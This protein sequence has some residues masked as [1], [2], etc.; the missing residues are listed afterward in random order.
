M[1]GL[2]KRLTDSAFDQ[3]ANRQ[4]SYLFGVMVKTSDVV[5]K[6]RS[7]WAYNSLWGRSP[8]SGAMERDGQIAGYSVVAPDH[9][10]LESRKTRTYVDI[11]APDLYSNAG[12]KTVAAEDVTYVHMVTN[13]KSMP[14]GVSCYYY[15]NATA[16]QSNTQTTKEVQEDNVAAGTKPADVGPDN[17]NSDVSSSGRNVPTQASSK[18]VMGTNAATGTHM[19]PNTFMQ[20]LTANFGWRF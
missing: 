3:K 15:K 4:P 13:N 19:V 17:V 5:S 6:V 9:D 14:T 11:L 16:I 20:S 1:D 10:R 18:T 2:L 8:L 12:G 7:H